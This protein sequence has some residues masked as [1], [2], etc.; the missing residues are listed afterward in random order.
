[1]HDTGRRNAGGTWEDREVILDR[2]WVS[3][4]RPKD[5]PAFNREMW[6][7]SAKSGRKPANT[8]PYNVPAI[9]ED[10]TPFAQSLPTP[11]LGS[12]IVT[13]LL[14]MLAGHLVGAIEAGF[15]LFLVRA[16]FAFF[17]LPLFLPF[18]FVGVFRQRRNGRGRSGRSRRHPWCD[19]RDRRVRD[20]GWLSK[21]R[22]AERERN[23][24]CRQT[25]E[26]SLHRSSL[27]GS[28][29]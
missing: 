8:P 20:R 29:R 11:L 10:F 2:N 22:R 7:S 21:R 14:A 15:F 4:R 16:F 3:S 27:Y 18:V 17:L 25:Y 28:H 12:C 19:G 9:R 26:W 6:C 13:T 1:S 24:K 23:Q 5:L